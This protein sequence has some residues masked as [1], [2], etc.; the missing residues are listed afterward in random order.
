MVYLAYED[1]GPRKPRA[2]QYIK[3]ATE[4]LT[5]GATTLLEFADFLGISL[6]DWQAKVGLC[7]TTNVDKKSF[8]MALRAPNEAGTSSRIA[9]LASLCHL[10][11]HPA[12]K[13]VYMS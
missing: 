11:R 9:V 1:L 8:K 4:T 2:T 13:V 6:Y 12:G 10:F 5:A 3:M 7:I